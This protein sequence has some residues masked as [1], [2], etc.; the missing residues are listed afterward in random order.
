VAFL[1]TSEN[2]DSLMITPRRRALSRHSVTKIGR[3]RQADDDTLSPN[4][5]LAKT[6]SQMIDRER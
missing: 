1:S 6:D 4:L 3:P 5:S 2:G